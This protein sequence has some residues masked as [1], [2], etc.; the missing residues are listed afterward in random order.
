M[1]RKARGELVYDLL[2]YRG[3]DA[4]AAPVLCNHSG[5]REIGF[6]VDLR[7]L[8]GQWRDREAC[9]GRRRPARF[10]LRPLGFGRGAKLHR[11]DVL[12]LYG[13]L[14]LDGDRAELDLHAANVPM[15][16]GALDEFRTRHA[17]NDIGNVEKN[18][19]SVAWGKGNS[20][21]VPDDQAGTP[22]DDRASPR[23]PVAGAT[24][25]AVANETRYDLRIADLN[26]QFTRTSVFRRAE[27]ALSVALMTQRL[28]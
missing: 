2:G 22:L 6:Y 5:E 9:D 19:P 20:E 10:H 26:R 7:V 15:L 3:D 12:E 23:Y 4:G 21:G 25:D 16:A 1:P 27:L 13:A 14:E 8:A 17:G 28:C 24:V 18:L 11:V